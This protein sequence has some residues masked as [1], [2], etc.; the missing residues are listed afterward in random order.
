MLRIHVSAEPRCVCS[1]WWPTALAAWTL[2]P[3]TDGS[4]STGE[5]VVHTFCSGSWTVFPFWIRIYAQ[6]SARHILILDNITCCESWCPADIKWSS[7]LLTDGLFLYFKSKQDWSSISGRSQGNWQAAEYLWPC[8]RP[9]SSWIPVAA[10]QNH[11]RMYGGWI[12]SIT[13]GFLELGFMSF[14]SEMELRAI[15]NAQFWITLWS[16]KRQ[17]A[18]P[19]VSQLSQQ[20]ASR[21]AGFPH[22][23]FTLDELPR[24]LGRSVH[25][26][27]K[28]SFVISKITIGRG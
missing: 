14:I 6:Y 26:D 10:K 20:Q 13:K 22:H 11:L 24:P 9:L 27:G 19:N 4:S 1:L 23:G 16:V 25:L 28:G 5:D 21:K 12:Y 17:T 7:S 8:F 18:K 3:E 2:D 15:A